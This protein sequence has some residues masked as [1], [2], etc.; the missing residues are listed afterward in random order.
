MKLAFGQVRARR[1]RIYLLSVVL[2]SSSCVWGTEGHQSI[3]FVVSG[4]AMN[5]VLQVPICSGDWL[6]SIEVVLPGQTIIQEASGKLEDNR[7][8]FQGIMDVSINLDEVENVPII[9]SFDLIKSSKN[10]LSKEDNGTVIFVTNE[11]YGASIELEDVATRPQ[12][13]LRNDSGDY[14]RTEVDQD[15]PSVISS[16]CSSD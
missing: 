15:I 13:W 12:L 16:W 8:R 9:S 11:G 5:Y 3:P 1:S 4:D 2:V 14:D 6:A 10:F 7:A